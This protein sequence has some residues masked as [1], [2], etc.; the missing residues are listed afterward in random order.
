MAEAAV[1]ERWT[2]ASFLAWLADGHGGENRWELVD[3]QPMMMAPPVARHSIVVGNVA[4]M[5]RERLRGGPCRPFTG[6]L[7]VE[8]RPDQFRLPDIVVDCE[9]GGM[10]DAMA[11]DP[12]VV[13]EV[14]LPSARIL[15]TF[16]KL[17]EYKGLAALHHLVAIDPMRMDVVLWTR[18]GGGWAYERLTEDATLRLPA[19]D[20]ELPLA[21]IYE[22]VTF[23]D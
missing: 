10:D 18:E 11:S 7:G 1:Q 3:G 2:T 19:L 12:K 16:D 6:D 5:L 15:N 20:A 22:D 9:P 4:G 14:P 8:T 23:G 21:D 17:E 13:V